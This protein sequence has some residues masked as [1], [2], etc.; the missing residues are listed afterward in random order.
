[1]SDDTI[2]WLLEG[3]PAIRFQTLRDLVSASARRVSTERARVAREGWGRRL[4]DLQGEDGRWTA[5]RGPARF[6]GLYIP[7]WTST[8]YTMLLL[9]HLGLPPRNRQA[10]AGCRE[11]VDFAEW[12]PSGGLGYFASRRVAEH[13]V[14]AM[15]LSIL[16]T[17]D[18]EHAARDRLA[19]FL[20]SEQLEDGGW[21]CTIGARH[22]SFN[23][24]CAAMEAL[25]LRPRTKEVKRALE[26]G[27]EF[28][29]RHQLFCSHRTGKT[30]RAIFTQLAPLIGWRYDVLRGLELF[31]REGAPRDARME[32]AIALV[33]KRRRRDGRWNA[34][35]PPAGA[36]HFELE[37]AGAPSRWTTL[38]CLRVLRWWEARACVP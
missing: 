33:R 2:E 3:D 10:L 19:R 24:T 7:K 8:T 15:V 6:R 31:A 38:R 17:F 37:R 18:T 16:E 11:L 5:D 4:L 22:S 34:M 28:F 1:M 13:C 30:V 29:L 14:S 9:R 26:R 35:S 27:S 12:F 36:M 23:T 20:L 32:R 21:N 25:Q